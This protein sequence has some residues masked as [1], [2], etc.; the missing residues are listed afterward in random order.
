MLYT[1]R[2]TASGT[3]IYMR[4]NAAIGVIFNSNKSQ[5]LLVKRQDIPLWVLPGGASRIM[6]TL[7]KLLL[8][9]C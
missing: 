2:L 6:K 7:A 1:I 5:V 4:K 8:E 9:K 3:S